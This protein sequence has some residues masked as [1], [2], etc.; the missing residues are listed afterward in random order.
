MGHWIFD[1]SE[2]SRLVSDSMDRTLPF[3]QRI[4]IRIHLLM[5]RHCTRYRKQL[6][7]LRKAI[8]FPS[9]TAADEKPSANLSDESCNRIKRA[10]QNHLT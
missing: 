8:R 5:C 2:I 6:L 9:T 1:C 10:I 4:G 7:F 3:R